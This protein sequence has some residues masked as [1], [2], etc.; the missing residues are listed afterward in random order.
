KVDIPNVDLGGLKGDLVESLGFAEEDIILAS[1]K[2]GQGVE[3]I[4]QAIIDRI[5]AP[6]GESG[7]TRALV[8]DSSFDTYKGVIAAV[9]VVDG[10]VKVGDKIKLIGSGAQ[11][12]A[13]DVGFFV[14]TL[15]PV[16]KLA[17]GEVG[18]IAT[19]LKNVG[20]VQVG[21]TISLTSENPSPLPGYRPAKPMVFAGIF[22]TEADQ[23]TRLREAL[24]KL[25]LNDAALTYQG[26]NSLALGF[27]FRVGFLGLLHMEV[28]QERLEREYDLELIASA[29][30]VPYEIK[31]TDGS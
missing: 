17:A 12:E 10:E 5:P 27:G 13:L 31:L 2:T 4:L 3:E 18:Y 26:E 25:K 8:F 22:P 24:G 29:P 23:F 6:Q 16:G 30:T 20:E 28:V 15:K 7:R 1:G 11:A 9:R 19:G 14:P 21:D